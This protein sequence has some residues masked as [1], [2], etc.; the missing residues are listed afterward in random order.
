M[1]GGSLVR[2]NRN[3]AIGILTMTAVFLLTFAVLTTL[4]PQSQALAIGQ[5][6][7]GGDYKMVTGQFTQNSEVV[8]LLDAAAKRLN[9]YSYDKTRRQFLLWESLDMKQLGVVAP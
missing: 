9:I 7:R 5:S 1:R 2:D 8:Y 3:L 6:D 4:G